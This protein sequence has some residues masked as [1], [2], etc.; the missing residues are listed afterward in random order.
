M[1][2]TYTQKAYIHMGVLCIYTM[3][4]YTAQPKYII[5]NTNH[6]GYLSH[7]ATCSFLTF[8]SCLPIPVIYM[9]PDCSGIDIIL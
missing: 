4:L 9:I 6:D 8:T 3:T 1:A 2:D 5:Y 7:L